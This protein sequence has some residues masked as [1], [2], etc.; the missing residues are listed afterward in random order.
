VSNAKEMCGD[1]GK[2]MRR[3]GK[4]CAG[5]RDRMC[6]ERS[7]YCLRKQ[8]LWGRCGGEKQMINFIATGI[9]RG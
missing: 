5:S 7:F 1:K 9:F 2:D 8:R 4:G 6:G 3:V